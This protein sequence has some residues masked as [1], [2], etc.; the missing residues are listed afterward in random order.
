MASNNNYTVCLKRGCLLLVTDCKTAQFFLYF[1]HY[2]NLKATAG[3]F[4]CTINFI[5]AAPIAYFVFQKFTTGQEFSYVFER[6]LSD[7]S[8]SLVCEKSLMGCNQYIAESQKSGEHVIG[9]NLC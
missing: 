2:K 6:S 4:L 8:D 1:L 3:F 7:I 9:Q 5:F